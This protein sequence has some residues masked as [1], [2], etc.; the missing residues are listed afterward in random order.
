MGDAAAH[1]LADLLVEV[2]EGLV[3][4][5]V[6]KKLV[7]YLDSYEW[8]EGYRYE[9]TGGNEDTIQ[10]FKDLLNAILADEDGNA[11]VDAVVTIFAF[12]VGGAGED[13]FLIF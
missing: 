13:A 4:A 11:E 3:P 7:P 10:S 6:L 1:R 2:P 12:E 9:L 5:D 8:P